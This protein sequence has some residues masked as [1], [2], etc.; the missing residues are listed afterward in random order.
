MSL[1]EPAISRAE[2]GRVT[3]QVIAD[4][5]DVSTATVSLA[6]RDSPVVAESTKRKVQKVAR[7]LGYIYNRSAASLRTA[8]TNILGV[9]FH[10]I[11]NPYFAEILAAVDEA[12]RATGRTVLLGTCAEDVE[13]QENVLS[14]LRE[15]RPD[16]LIVCPV[17]GSTQSSLRQIADSGIP[18][19]QI[20]REVED[21]KADFVGA[22]D[23]LGTRLAVDHLASL[24][25]RRIAFVG[26]TLET[27]T[28]RIRHRSFRETL[29]A[30]GL[31]FEPNLLMSGIANRVTGIAAVETMMAMAEPPTAVICLNDLVAFGIMHG[32]IK[33]G[34]RPAEHLSVVGCDDV[35]EAAQ[36]V[37]ALTTIHNQHAEM[38]RLAA[39]LLL[40]RIQDPHGDQ[41]R[42]VLEPRLI[43]RGTTAA[44]A[45][46]G[47]RRHH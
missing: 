38:G 32:L 20:A 45:P 14:M 39:E 12:V 11:T 2:R 33:H 43:V 7:D 27:S 16:G 15:Y 44:P 4:K 18:I 22:D 3:L 36:W 9:A 46:G 34:L 23:S 21:L 5:L 40:A 1:N 17:G 35:Q 19:V 26:G 29:G 42:I 24:G 31:P 13:R 25:H 47:L 37:P 6:L 41:R 28:G 10:D 8:R 30:Y